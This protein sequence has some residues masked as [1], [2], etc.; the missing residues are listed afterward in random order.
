[1]HSEFPNALYIEHGTTSFEDENRKL[2]SFQCFMFSDRAFCLKDSVAAPDRPFNSSYL[3]E[4]EYV[5]FGGLSLT[6]LLPLLLIVLQK[7]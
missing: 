7:M 2:S 1:V 3:G 5:A 6:M 4:N